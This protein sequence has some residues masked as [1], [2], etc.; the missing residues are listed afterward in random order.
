MRVFE[1]VNAIVGGVILREYIPSI[2]KGIRRLFEN[3]VI[4]ESSGRH[5]GHPVDGSTTIATLRLHSTAGL[6]ALAILSGARKR[7]KTRC[8]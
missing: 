8:A 7:T 4:V 5:Q 1:F 3:G 6:L 2:D